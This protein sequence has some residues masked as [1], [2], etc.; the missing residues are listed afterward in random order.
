MDLLWGE[1]DALGNDDP[2]IF[3]VDV[4]ALDG[5]IVCAGTR[6]HVGPVEVAGSGIDHDAIWQM[7]IGDNDL[8]VGAVG[9]HR[10]NAAGAH[11]ENE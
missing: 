7:T 5:A 2:A 4:S 6:S 3:A 9:I 1:R 11:F 8:L 10:M